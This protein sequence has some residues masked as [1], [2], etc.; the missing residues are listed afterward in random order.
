ME[1]KLYTL[2]GISRDIAQVLFASMFVGPILS[3]MIDW[4]IIISGLT[5]SAACWWLS[6][7]LSK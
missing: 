7:S 6:L 1:T 3:G 4:A 2:S 5:L